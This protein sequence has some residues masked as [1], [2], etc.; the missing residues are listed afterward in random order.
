MVA[1]SAKA[2]QAHV[3]TLSADHQR[4]RDFVVLELPISGT[5]LSPAAIAQETG[6]SLA[7]VQEIV[8]DLE[9]GMTFLFRNAQG[10]VAWAYPVTVEPTPHRITFE[11]GEQVYA[12]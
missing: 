8:E 12:A 1:K 5:P 10:E 7:R 4:V 3:H 6:L 9:R 2:N 11:T